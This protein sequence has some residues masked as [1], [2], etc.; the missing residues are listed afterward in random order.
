MCVCVC[1]TLY[2]PEDT[3]ISYLIILVTYINAPLSLVLFMS[4]YSVYILT[5]PVFVFM[6]ALHSRCG[7]YIFAL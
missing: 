3:H 7:H 5:T 4:L 6:A 2:V 1:V